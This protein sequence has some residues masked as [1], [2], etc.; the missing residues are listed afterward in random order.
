[1]MNSDRARRHG[2][3]LIFALI[4]AVWL[5]M[6]GGLMI[7]DVWDETNALLLMDSEPVSGLGPFDI[8]WLSWSESIGG[9]YRPLGATLTLLLGKLF[10]GNFIWLRYCNALLVLGSVGLLARTLVIRYQLEAERV[11]AFFVILLFSASSLITASWF[12]NIFDAACLFF[13][14]LAI[15]LYVSGNLLACGLSFAAAVCCKEA[16]VLAFPVFAWMLWEDWVGLDREERGRRIWLAGAMFAISAAYWLTRQ[17]LVPLGSDADIHGFNVDVYA[18]SYT[19]F[20][21]GFLAQSSSFTRGDPIFWA[22][23]AA[24]VAVVVAMRS[25]G[26]KFTILAILGLA[27]PVYWGMFGYQGENLMSFHNFVGRLYLVPFALC[28]FLMMISARRLPVLLIALC[29]IWGMGVTWRQHQAFQQTYAEIYR[30]AETREETL[31]VHYPQKPLDDAGRGLVI[32]DFP[33]SEFRI[34]IE[35]GGIE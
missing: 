28:L 1:M 14:A 9:V 34:N 31:R 35:Q 10:N 12:A 3:T 29:S 18:A 22:G 16:Y 2:L 27:G 19:S 6:I 4:G 15:R 7:A 20:I 32:G 8:V 21:A 23:L 17:L 24:M 30:L 5:I 25:I 26:Q 33:E 13:L 11:V